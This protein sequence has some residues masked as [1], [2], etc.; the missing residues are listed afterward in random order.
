MNRFGGL[1]APISKPPGFFTLEKVGNRWTLIDPDG[2]RYWML[3]VDAID[4]NIAGKAGVE[5]MKAKYGQKEVDGKTHTHL[6]RI[7]AATKPTQ[8]ENPEIAAHYGMSI[9]AQYS[10]T[11]LYSKLTWRDYLKQKYGT[12][13]AL[14]GAL[15][16]A[17]HQL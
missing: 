3:A 1:P 12:I 10:D 8:T 4:W 5:A 2:H 17:R 13:E 6:G 7:V 9:K 14:N 11:T 16:L 15:G